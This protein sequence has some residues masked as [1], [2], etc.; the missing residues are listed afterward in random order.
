MTRNI[1]IYYISKSGNNIWHYYS[2]KSF[3]LN[4]I[5]PPADF[6]FAS[7]KYEIQMKDLLAYNKY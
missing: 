1:N 2:S 3:S 6:D 4:E 5:S 7:T